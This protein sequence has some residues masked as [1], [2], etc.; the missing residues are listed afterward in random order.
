MLKPKLTQLELEILDALWE[1]GA[2]VT[3]VPVTSARIF[4]LLRAASPA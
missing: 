2:R 3:R 4:E 1:R